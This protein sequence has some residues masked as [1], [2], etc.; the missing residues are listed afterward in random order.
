[1]IDGVELHGFGLWTCTHT[2]PC[3][4]LKHTC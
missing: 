1:V 4:F 3:N 2:Y